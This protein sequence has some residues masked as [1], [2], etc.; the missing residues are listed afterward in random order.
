MHTNKLQDKTKRMR[1]EKRK[2]TKTH[3][4]ISKQKSNGNV[5][6][7][8]C[9]EKQVGNVVC[10]RV[11]VCAMRQKQQ[12]RWQRNECSSLCRRDILAVAKDYFMKPSIID[13]KQWMRNI[14]N[15][16]LWRFLPS[17]AL[18]WRYSTK[19]QQRLKYC[20]ICAFVCALTRQ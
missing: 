16:K 7:N 3:E 6:E 15:S 20:F 11:C 10:C 2:Q 18:R 19:R 14:H 9:G 5:T 13:E 8:E 17:V 12:I 4:N 1:A